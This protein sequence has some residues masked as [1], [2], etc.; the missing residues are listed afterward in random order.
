MNEQL[1]AGAESITA[2]H[3]A[4]AEQASAGQFPLIRHS[5]GV[6]PGHCARHRIHYVTGGRF[7]LLNIYDNI[8]PV[9]QAAQVAHCQPEFIPL[10]FRTCYTDELLALHEHLEAEIL[11]RFS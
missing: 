1:R 11:R 2:E 5:A 6:A 3:Y 9:V 10:A 8:A 4:R 7:P